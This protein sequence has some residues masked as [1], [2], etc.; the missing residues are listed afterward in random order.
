MAV[1]DHPVHERVKIGA[2][3][4][5]GCHNRPAEF[6]PTCESKFSGE[7]WPFNNSHECRFDLSLTD[8]SC[9]GCEHRGSGEQYALMV[10]TNG[11]S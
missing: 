1:I 6:K 3:H 2:D 7:T 11:Y 5:Y 8:H 9:T 4:R 10:K